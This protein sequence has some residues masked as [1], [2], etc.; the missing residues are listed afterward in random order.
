MYL[1][2]IYFKINRHTKQNTKVMVHINFIISGKEIE[3]FHL[4]RGMLIEL[5]NITPIMMKQ[6]ANILN[7]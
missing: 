4:K 7:T 2:A 6:K 3:T 1:S 5:R